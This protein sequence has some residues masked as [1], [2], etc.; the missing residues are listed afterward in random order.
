MS[1]INDY[2]KKSRAAKTEPSSSSTGD[3]PPVMKQPQGGQRVAAKEK[4]IS[5]IIVVLLVFIVLLGGVAYYLTMSSSSPTNNHQPDLKVPGADPVDERPEIR[6]PTKAIN[7]G[8]VKSES[9]YGEGKK[10]KSKLQPMLPSD[11]NKDRNLVVPVVSPNLEPDPA[12]VM[13]EVESEAAGFGASEAVSFDTGAVNIS[14]VSVAGGVAG[15]EVVQP[16]P[17]RVRRLSQK[18]DVDHLFQV[19][20]LALSSGNRNRAYYYFNQ[21]LGLDGKHQEALLNMAVICLQDNDFDKA[22]K[23]LARAAFNDPLDARVKVNQGLIALKSDNHEKAQK[24]FT[25]ALRL[26]PGAQSALNNLAW[27]AQQRGDK[28]AAAEYYRNLVALD[29]Q[30]L[31][32]LLAYASLCEQTKEFNQSLSLY[33]EA[34]KSRFLE[35]DRPLERRIRA[36]IK[37]LTGYVE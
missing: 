13:A 27:L 19:G 31:K 35:N 34:L 36:R 12:A 16:A 5:L 20:V 10:I 7:D 18:D 3:V 24:L 37:L 23:L 6:P 32:P 8:L 33:R 29:P 4:K 15:E 26:D 25:E 14:S 17:T 9:R 21:V 22:L 28:R 11:L 30:N 2:L 1:L